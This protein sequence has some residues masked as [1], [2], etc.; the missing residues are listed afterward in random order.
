MKYHSRTLK[1]DYGINFKYH[2]LCH[3][4]GTN[5]ATANTPTHILCNQMGH[6]KI[7]TTK[8]YYI[9]VSQNGIDALLKN[10]NDL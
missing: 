6:G 5:L 4:Y 8:K 9:G 10:L 1:Q 7:E 3:T 2:F